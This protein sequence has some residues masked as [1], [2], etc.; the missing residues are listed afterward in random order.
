MRSLFV[1]AAL[2]LLA[3]DWQY[4][5]AQKVDISKLEKHP[6]PT[7]AQLAKNMVTSPFHEEHRKFPRGGKRTPGHKLF[8]AKRFD[9]TKV[10]SVPSQVLMLPTQ[11]SMWGNSQ[12]GDCVSASEAARLAAYSVF[13]G[14]PEIF[15]P[16]AN[17]ISW[18]QQHGYLNGADLP[19]VMTTMQTQG[20]TAS[21]G[22][23]YNDG[24][25]TT[26]NFGDE[27]TLQAALA[28]G[29]VNFGMD[30]NALPSGAGNQS[31]WYAFG[32]SPG[33]FNSDDHC[34][35]S[36]GYVKGPMGVTAA[37]AAVAKAYNV[38]ITPPANAPTG[39]VYL[40][41]T[42][43]TVGIVDFAWIQSTASECWICNPNTVGLTPGPNPTPVP[44]PTP[45]PVPPT[46]TPAP[47]PTPTP[48]PTPGPR[49]PRLHRILHPF[50]LFGRRRGGQAMY[51]ESTYVAAPQRPIGRPTVIEAAP[52]CADGSC[53][54]GFFG[55]RRR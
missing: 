10:A 3:G 24:P 36:F 6:G 22:K 16:E 2:L 46:P 43:S 51:A 20:M 47:P 25:Y 11:L 48:T 37:F 32:G 55:R 44:D 52:S 53:Q 33:Q 7:P 29:P 4:A 19:S 41:Y 28:S 8:A 23:V 27:P 42:W 34:T 54:Q 13:V 35:P 49:F 12:Y 1:V 21:D 50:G 38:S 17:V 45:T 26:V 39:N 40:W 18:A 31:G 15:V 9:K 14:M 5:H 30:A